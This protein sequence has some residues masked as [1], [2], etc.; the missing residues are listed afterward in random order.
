[1]T[2]NT[3]PYGVVSSNISSF[4]SGYEAY[5]AFGNRALPQGNGYIKYALKEKG[6]K[7]FVFINLARENASATSINVDILVNGE[8]IDTISY[9][10]SS[11]YQRKYYVI[12]V[13]N[14][15]VS[16]IGVQ[17]NALQAYYVGIN[18]YGLD[19]SEKE[20]EEG[21]TKKWLYDHGVELE[22]LR[23]NKGN[24]A[25]NAIIKQNDQ[26]ILKTNYTGVDGNTNVYSVA[27]FENIDFTPYTLFRC[28]IGNRM[29][30]VTS[31]YATGNVFGSLKVVTDI[32]IACP[33][34]GSAYQDSATIAEIAYID[35]AFFPNK[36][37][38]DVSSL[39]SIYDVFYGLEYFSGNHEASLSELWLE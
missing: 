10:D 22:N 33:D 27:G 15:E 34:G 11:L 31:R 21:T 24:E 25:N 37:T 29:I 2:G 18:Y 36:I 12:D 5:K 20:F 8:V 3:T 32:D 30:P 23:L 39:K 17:S 35:S 1:M 4:T 13:S 9:S 7:G 16:E 6:S 26:I 14:D 19:Y 38:L 28:A